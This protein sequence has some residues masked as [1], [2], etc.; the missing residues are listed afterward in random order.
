MGV[1]FSL[2]V[3][4]KVGDKLVQIRSEGKD[5][6]FC[7]DSFARL[8]FDEYRARIEWLL[9]HKLSLDFYESDENAYFD[10]DKVL[11]TFRSILKVIKSN[12]NCFPHFYSVKEEG[13]KTYFSHVFIHDQEVFLDTDFNVCS[14]TFKMKDEPGYEKHFPG[15]D[16]DVIKE[17]DEIEIE[18]TEEGEFADAVKDLMVGLDESKT[19][20]REN[21]DKHSNKEIEDTFWEAMK[22]SVKKSGYRKNEEVYRDIRRLKEIKCREALRKEV[23]GEWILVPGKETTIMIKRISF[24]DFFRQTLEEFIA[25][26]EYAKSKGYYVQGCGE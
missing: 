19:I 20:S 10:A 26:C 15:E 17:E 9:G 21:L 22:E 12:E 24:Y 13:R 6:A 14:Y 2:R 11:Q 8:L 25:V 3:V 1:D 4:N 5:F 16:K 23:N 18:G 7:S